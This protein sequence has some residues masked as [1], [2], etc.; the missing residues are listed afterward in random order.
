[1]TGLTFWIEFE[2]EGVMIVCDEGTGGFWSLM[3]PA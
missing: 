2:G 3:P 1:L